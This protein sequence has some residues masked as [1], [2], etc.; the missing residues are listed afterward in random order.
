MKAYGI[1]RSM[2]ELS[3]HKIASKSF[4]MLRFL[5]P[6]I[7]IIVMSNH[8]SIAMLTTIIQYS[9]PPVYTAPITSGHP[10]GVATFRGP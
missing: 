6:V 7:T 8:K 9:G 1:L 10:S 4:S 5:L 3:N 2:A